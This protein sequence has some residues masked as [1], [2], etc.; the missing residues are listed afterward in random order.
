MSVKNRSRLLI[1]LISA[2]LIFTSVPITTFAVD[3]VSEGPYEEEEEGV[4][5][6]DE[7]NVKSAK[8]QAV[9]E[10]IYGCYGVKYSRY[11]GSGQCYGYAEMIRQH[12][13]KSYKQRNCRVKASGANL[14]KYLKK[15]KPG[16]HVRFTQNKNGS[17]NA[18]SIVILQ[19]KDNLVW[20]TDGNVDWNNGIRFGIASIE[21]LRPRSDYL[22]FI[23]EPKGA[24]PTVS[25]M[26][27]RAVREFDNPVARVA[28]RPVKK[29]K[30]YIVY[31]STNKSS[32]YQEIATVKT[33]RFIDRS[34]DPSGK[35]FYK[36]KA[37]MSKKKT[38]T[39]KPAAVTRKLKA[40]K[41][42]LTQSA[43]EDGNNAFT[44][45]WEPISGA[46]KY[47][48]YYKVDG[49][50]K[51]ETVTDTKWTYSGSIYPNY[52]EITAE[53]SRPDSESARAYLSL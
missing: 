7:I 28:W 1:C 42:Y 25:E 39:S 37:V 23:R 26:N 30:K 12:F 34:A 2:I 14:K 49:Q 11:K 10:Y 27:I 16:T 19:V 46:A 24:V 6:I 36:V 20:F 8:A 47:N 53:G 50:K 44:L 5:Y 52:F 9:I 17:G 4:G 48:I 38:K 21:W 29:A 35:V 18:H 31:R 32:G 45:T 15:C 41:V 22:A 13:G 51:K 3:A 43:D 40:P 33:C